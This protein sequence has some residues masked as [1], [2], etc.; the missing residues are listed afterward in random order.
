MLV[1]TLKV[2]MLPTPEQVPLLLETFQRFNEACNWI[3]QIAFREQ[4]FRQV[5][6]HAACYHTVREKFGLCAQLTVRAISK[7]IETYRTDKSVCHTF[8][9]YS[10]VVYDERVFRIEGVAY[11]SLRLLNT[12]QRVRMD[13]GSY[14][15]RHLA[16]SPNIG[17]V[18]LLYERGQFTL[19]I[20]I[21]KPEPPQRETKGVLG[22]DLGITEIATDSEGNQYSGE[23]I[24]SC[25]RRYRKFRQGL[26]S[27]G[28]KGA[29]RRL[30]TIS[31][32]QSRFVRWANHNLS[33]Q[34]VA[35]ALEAGKALALEDLTG[36]R[37]RST[38][39]SASMRWLLGNW[40]F[41][42]LRE[43]VAYKSEDVGLPV[44]FVGARNTSRTCSRCGHCE[45]SNRKS[46]ACFLC[47]ECGFQTNADYNAA[48][49]IA[50]KGLETRA[51]CNLA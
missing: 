43:F 3:S 2:K 4:A 13:C 20:S 25:R 37:E 22:I 49:N 11:T 1:R 48:C 14:Q 19:A 12:R 38:G 34:L 30:L 16:G 36:I 24:Q 10:A 18:D 9:T 47:L 44:L 17:Q 32:K 28:K 8:G 45:K 23:A 21:R 7:V 27:C 29:K 5:P 42:Q 50:C 51:T 26:Q 33:K 35:T 39:Y 41:F 46:Q 40:A 6:L 31:R 15:R